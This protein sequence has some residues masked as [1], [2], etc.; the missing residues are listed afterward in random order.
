MRTHIGQIGK[1]KGLRVPKSVLTQLRFEGEVELE[2]AGDAL[3]VRRAR[4]PREGT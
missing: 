3:V 1:S 2:V 4:S